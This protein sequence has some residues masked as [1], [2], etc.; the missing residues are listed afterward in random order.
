MAQDT[1][2]LCL[3]AAGAMIDASETEARASRIAGLAA[4]FEA[5]LAT[6]PSDEAREIIL[7]E[8][9]TAVGDES[10]KRGRPKKDD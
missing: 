2:A 1:S 3:E 5:R 10:P 6:A 4:K 9:H 7:K 8:L